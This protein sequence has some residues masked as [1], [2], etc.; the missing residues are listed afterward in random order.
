LL[1][2]WHWGCWLCL[3]RLDV[4]RWLL[5]S[6]LLYARGRLLHCWLLQTRLLHARGWLLHA[7]LLHAWLLHSWLLHSWLLLLLHLHSRLLHAKRR[8]LL[9][10]ARDLLL[11]RHDRWLP[12]HSELPYSRHV[13]CETRRSLQARPPDIP[14]GRRRLCV[15]T[16]LLA[17]RGPLVGLC[18][19][20]LWLVSWLEAHVDVLGRNARDLLSLWRWGGDWVRGHGRRLSR[21]SVDVEILLAKF[22]HDPCAGL[23]GPRMAAADECVDG[24][25]SLPRGND[26]GLKSRIFANGGEDGGACLPELRVGTHR[27][28]R[29]GMKR[30]FVLNHGLGN[31]WVLEPHLKRLDDR[32]L[33]PVVAV[34]S[35]LSQLS[36]CVVRVLERLCESGH[37]ADLGAGWRAH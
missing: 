37:L 36:G 24:P 34:F 4:G 25:K 14:L 32:R 20:L 27:G 6:R 1:L 23:K 11:A 12:L 2:R 19:R 30:I 31:L 35:N 13:P 7:G 18:R 26:L 9:R 29:S 16:Q 5:H 28:R 17:R 3:P 8:L 33:V 10:G 22:R 21:S 15:L